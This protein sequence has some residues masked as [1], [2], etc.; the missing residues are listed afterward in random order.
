MVAS[1]WNVRDQATSELM[2]RFYTH[3]RSGLPVDE[4]L[5]AAQMEL[6]R[7]PVHGKDLSAPYYWAAFQVHGDWR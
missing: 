4:A 1:L 7:E 2:V 6:I 3:L 5:R